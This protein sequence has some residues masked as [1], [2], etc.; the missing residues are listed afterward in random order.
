[1]PDIAIRPAT[2]ADGPAVGVLFCASA[3]HAYDAFFPPGTCAPF[4]THDRHIPRWTQRIEN[5]APG[6]QLLVATIPDRKNDPS[7]RIIAGFIEVG[8][9][10]PE[11]LDLAPSTPNIGEIH[12]IFCD[13]RFLGAGIGR[14]LLVA[15]EDALRRTPITATATTA[16]VSENQQQFVDTAVIHVFVENKEACAFYERLGYV[17]L[18]K[19]QLDKEFRGMGYDVDSIWYQKKL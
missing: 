11:S 6:H 2:P 3:I 10:D 7:K 9:R 5:L 8:P 14:A 4:Y 1:M 12:Y 18:G 15:G 19:V 16:D 17:S 13:P